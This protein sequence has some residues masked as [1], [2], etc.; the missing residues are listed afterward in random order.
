MEKITGVK[1][2][3]ENKFLDKYVL[4]KLTGIPEKEL[5]KVEREYLSLVTETEALLI[6][7]EK[8]KE[9]VQQARNELDEVKR[10][11]QE[12]VDDINNKIQISQKNLQEIEKK[13][14][15]LVDT[16]RKEAL[17]KIKKQIDD[18]SKAKELD[19]KKQ[20][21]KLKAFYQKIKNISTAK[22][23]DINI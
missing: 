23:L 18:Y 11:R 4:S 12:T 6:G 20:M 22:K 7:K 13:K 16:Y 8:I 10:Q 1:I 3:I 19:I 5:E 9:E 21:D 15:D 14:N 17:E 2:N